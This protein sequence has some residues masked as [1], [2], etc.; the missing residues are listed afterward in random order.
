MKRNLDSQHRKDATRRRL[1]AAARDIVVD[2]GFKALTV[3]SLAAKAEISTGYVYKHFP[4]KESIS[5]AMFNEVAEQDFSALRDVILGQGSPSVRLHTA[6]KTVV[7]QALENPVFTYAMRAESV[8]EGLQE[9]RMEYRHFYEEAFQTL[10]EQ[11]IQTGE[12]APQH[13]K[14][15]AACLIGVIWDSMLGRLVHPELHSDVP[16]SHFIA[17]IQCFCL[18]ALQNPVVLIV[19]EAS[20]HE[21]TS[22]SLF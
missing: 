12:F 4:S 1:I 10:L 15:T 7:T 16:I 9:L 5:Y 21:M 8:D 20:G 19:S 17:G 22:V 18:G 2:G 14:V 11:G 3:V 6:I 13:P